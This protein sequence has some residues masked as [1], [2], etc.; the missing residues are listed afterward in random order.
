MPSGKRGPAG[1]QSRAWDE[2]VRAHMGRQRLSGK[3]LAAKSGVSQNYL[4]T[5]L[6]DEAPFTIDYV[7]PFR[8]AGSSGGCPRRRAASHRSED[9]A[10]RRQTEHRDTM[11]PNAEA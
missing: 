5:R 1:L 8:G 4:A 2:A 6:R 9:A 10:G 3:T 11:R 7:E